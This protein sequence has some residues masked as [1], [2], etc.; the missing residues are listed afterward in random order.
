[1]TRAVRQFE[2]IKVMVMA[3]PQVVAK[4]TEEESTAVA[5]LEEFIKLGLLDMDVIVALNVYTEFALSQYAAVFTTH[6]RAMAAR[7]NRKK[8]SK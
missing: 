8:S 6:S 5:E 4:I 7:P 3:S 1:M 2:A